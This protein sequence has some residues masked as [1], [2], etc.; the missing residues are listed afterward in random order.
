MYILVRM[1]KIRNGRQDV[2]LKMRKAANGGCEKVIRR[3]G[4]KGYLG[5]VGVCSGLASQKSLPSSI[6]SRGGLKCMA[7]PSMLF[8]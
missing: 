2:R 7:T 5:W 3:R 6:G 4:S 8:V 1:R